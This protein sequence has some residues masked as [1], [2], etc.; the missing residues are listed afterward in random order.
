MADTK[1]ICIV[2]DDFTERALQYPNVHLWD[3][4]NDLSVTSW[5]YHYYDLPTGISY[6]AEKFYESNKRIDYSR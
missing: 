5:D 4:G 2:V 1:Y 3:Y 6:F